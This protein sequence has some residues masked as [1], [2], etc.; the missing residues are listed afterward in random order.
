MDELERAKQEWEETTVK[1]TTDRFP[2]RRE[3]F[4]TV[5]IPAVVPDDVHRQP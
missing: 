1:Q 3:R 4:E 5:I 2:E